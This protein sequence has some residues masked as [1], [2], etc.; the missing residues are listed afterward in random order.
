MAKKKAPV[1][2]MEELI[3]GLDKDIKKKKITKK[4]FEKNLTK[5]IKKKDN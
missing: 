2:T 3:K 5:V 4:E 1:K